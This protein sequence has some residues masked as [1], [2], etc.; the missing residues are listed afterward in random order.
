MS[1]IDN[2]LRADI[3]RKRMEDKNI[4]K[5]KG[6][7]YIGL[8]TFDTEEGTD[9]YH[10]K[11]LI[12]G[13]N[14]TILVYNGDTVEWTNYTDWDDPEPWKQTEIVDYSE[15]A[16]V[17]DFTDIIGHSARKQTLTSNNTK[18]HIYINNIQTNN[19]I[20]SYVIYPVNRTAQNKMPV[21][22]SILKLYDGLY[23]NE[24]VIVGAPTAVKVTIPFKIDEN[25][26]WYIDFAPLFE[27][28]AASNTEIDSIQCYLTYIH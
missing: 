10:T 20:I 12:K 13:D 25:N 16:I 8:G 27:S 14:G 28:Q 4:L 19:F 5:N 9:I 24:K 22:Y 1:V 21:I 15:T 7:L 26:N 23:N 11:E 3:M 17:T 2:G 18:F 6:S